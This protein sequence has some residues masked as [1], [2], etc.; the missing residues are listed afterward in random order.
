[1]FLSFN[2]NNCNE[3]VGFFGYDKGYKKLSFKT[4]NMKS[5]RDT[6]AICEQKKKQLNMEMFNE[7][8]GEEKYTTENTK[9]LKDE[10]G[11]TIEEAVGNIELCILTEFVLRYFNEINKNN[12]KWFFTPEMA[13]YHNFYKIYNVNKK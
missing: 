7:L 4:K 5:I 9:V 10:K 8:I 12:K 1:M 3:L 13:I 2:I 6:G 11:N